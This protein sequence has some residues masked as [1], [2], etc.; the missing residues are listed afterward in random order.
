M[1]HTARRCS[2]R[3]RMPAAPLCHIHSNPKFCPSFAFAKPTSLPNPGTSR[4]LIC[5]GHCWQAFSLRIRETRA[6]LRPGSLFSIPTSPQT[7]PSENVEHTVWPDPSDV[8]PHMFQRITASRKTRA[9][10]PKTPIIASLRQIAA[11]FQTPP[12]SPDHRNSSR[13]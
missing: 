5:P 2:A 13:S 7:P 10:H 3:Q 4:I 8:Q 9:G 11:V 12:V 1:R 6:I